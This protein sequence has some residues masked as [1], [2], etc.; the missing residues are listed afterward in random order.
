MKKEEVNW[1][2]VYDDIVTTYNSLIKDGIISGNE[3]IIKHLMYVNKWNK[4]KI[5]YIYFLLNNDTGLTKIGATM[6]ISS[7]M[8]QIKSSFKNMMGIKPNLELVGLIACK[9]ENLTEVEKRMHNS[10]KDVRQFGEWFDLKNEDYLCD[11]IYP[12]IVIEDIP[13]SIEDGFVENDLDDNLHTT[14]SLKDISELD[15]GKTQDM[16][17][18]INLCLKNIFFV[19]NNSEDFV[20]VLNKLVKGDDFREKEWVDKI[21]IKEIG[22]AINIFK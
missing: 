21:D 13:V 20:E 17:D 2:I 10:F 8:R 11:L 19:S 15:F 6:N 7:R 16:Q 22:T 12:E 18:A 14:L 5:G 1:S 3:D 9:K 4:S